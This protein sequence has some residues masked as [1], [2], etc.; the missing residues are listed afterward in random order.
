[1]RTL[2]T[3][4]M[5]TFCDRS[6]V[7][8]SNDLHLAAGKKFLLVGTPQGDEIK[9]PLCMFFRLVLYSTNALTIYAL[10]LELSP[11]IVNDLDVDFSAD[12]QAAAAHANDQRNLRK[13]RE[14]TSKLTVNVMAPLREG[15]RLLVLDIDHSQFSEHLIFILFTMN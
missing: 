1:M 3:L 7:L 12:P 2:R 10:V 11:D 9:N 8:D 15:K 4:P 13:I 5:C 14:H 6:S